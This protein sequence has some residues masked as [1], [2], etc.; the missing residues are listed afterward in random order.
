MAVILEA[1]ALQD[2]LHGRVTYAAA[3]DPTLAAALLL[4]SRNS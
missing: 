4:A 2:R 1:L 3:Q